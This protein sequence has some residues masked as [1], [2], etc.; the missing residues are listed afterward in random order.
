MCRADNRLHFR[1]VVSVIVHQGDRAFGGLVIAVNLEPAPD[2]GKARQPAADGV[3]VNAL[4]CG[5]GNGRQ[6]VQ[7]I[8]SARHFQLDCQ[9]TATGRTL[10]H[11]VS[12]QT[13][14]IDALGTVIRLRVF[15]AVGNN[16]PGNPGNN[17]L[18]VTIIHTHHRN[19]V[20]RQVVQEI[21]EG[22]LQFLD[23]AAV[24][25]HVVRFDVGHH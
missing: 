22:L 12:P 11:E 15:D 24:G 21:H 25:V 6:R 5:H 8:V 7:D 10:H 20:K 18:N 19:T 4:V 17:L 9:I 14:G 13:I 16:R 3:I 23:I 1:G 2:P